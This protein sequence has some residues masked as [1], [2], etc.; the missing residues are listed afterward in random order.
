LTAQKFLSQKKTVCQTF[1]LTP[2]LKEWVRR[3][4]RVNNKKAPDKDQFK[5]VSA[6]ISTLLVKEMSEKANK[7]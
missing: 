3:Y 5:S 4:V 2:A 7:I 6:F 1:S